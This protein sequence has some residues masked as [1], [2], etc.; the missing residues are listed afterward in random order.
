MEE[1]IP[2]YA[3]PADYPEDIDEL[4]GSIA[5]SPKARKAIRN[6]DLVVSSLDE[7]TYD[8]IRSELTSLRSLSARRTFW[9]NIPKI[10][11]FPS[12][13]HWSPN[14]NLTR[15]QLMNCENAYSAHIPN[16]VRHFVGLQYLVVSTCGDWEDQI[17]SM[18]LSKSRY[19]D[20]SALCNVRKP[21]KSFQIEHMEDWELAA[22]GDIPTEKLII[23]NTEGQ[24]LGAAFQADRD[25][26][27]SL[28]CLQIES[29]VLQKDGK[30]MPVTYSEKAMSIL[31]TVCAA[32]SIELRND[33]EGLKSFPRHDK[34]LGLAQDD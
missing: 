19:T 7:S 4:L 16:L 12:A 14:P 11:E 31:R 26:F 10:W 17:I 27:P 18:P 13:R 34:E 15:L 21:L 32:R 3:D 2:P 22:M 23:T 6:L 25:L 28:R 5:L 8:L 24:H 33:A 1:D 29:Q 30:I 20:P 9:G